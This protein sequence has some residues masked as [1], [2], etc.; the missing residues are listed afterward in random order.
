MKKSFL[1]LNLHFIILLAGVLL[2]LVSAILLIMQSRDFHRS[3]TES[4]LN[5]KG[6][7]YTNSPATAMSLALELLN[8]EPKWESRTDGSSPFVSRPYLVK[9]GQL[10]DPMEGDTPLHPPV[11]NQWLIKNNL[12][13]T[14]MNILQKDPKGKGFTVL[15]EFE[16]GTNPNDPTQ[17]PPHCIKLSYSDTDLEKTSFVLEFLGEEE[18]DNRKEFLL[19]PSTPLAN[20][21][22]GGKPDTS[23]RGV[24]KG[25]TVPG[26]PFLKFVDYQNKTATINDAEYDVS[27]LVLENT[28]TKEH[29]TLVKKNTSRE[30]RGMLKPIELIKS[31]TFRYNLSGAPEQTIKVERGR[32][33]TLTNL[34]KTH[35]ETFTLADITP[36]GVVMQ[37]NGKTFTLQASAPKP[38]TPVSTDGT[39]VPASQP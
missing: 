26:A 1:Q 37:K 11:P 28:L 19:K 5:T 6:L 7:P 18:G 33:V 27:E 24:I 25:E 22:K 34:D 20:P 8:K 29:I 21:A 14:D 16:A 9:E 4:P 30:Y 23:A 13:Y 31:V 2:A 36:D 10:I 15:E 39:S 17:F 3:F 35:S 32:D 12:D 38:P